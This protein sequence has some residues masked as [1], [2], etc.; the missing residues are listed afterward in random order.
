MVRY[1]IEGFPALY[2]LQQLT[3]LCWIIQ[4]QIIHYQCQFYDVFGLRMVGSDEGV[5][6]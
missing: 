2:Y 6:S 5:D 4:R 1:N 3:L